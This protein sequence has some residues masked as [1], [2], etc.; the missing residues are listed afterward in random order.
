MTMFVLSN[1]RCKNDKNKQLTVQ[2]WSQHLCSLD[3][4]W[5]RLTLPISSSLLCSD[6][7]GWINTDISTESF[8]MRR[9]IKTSRIYGKCGVSD[10][11]FLILRKHTD[12]G[13][14]TVCCLHMCVLWFKMKANLSGTNWLFVCQQMEQKLFHDSVKLKPKDQN[15]HKN[16]IKVEKKRHKRKVHFLVCVQNDSN[17]SQS[18][19]VSCWRALEQDECPAKNESEPV[20]ALNHCWLRGWRGGAL[21]E[22][23]R[24]K[25]THQSDFSSFF[26]HETKRQRHEE[27]K[28]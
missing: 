6:F 12:T 7:S 14:L 19:S 3:H 23:C 24:K 20:S 16:L 8:K 21:R 25:L 15:V 26:C 18:D 4:L 13:F 28:H 5:L 11:F 2:E 1:H 22:L 17:G 9:C 27:D 10:I